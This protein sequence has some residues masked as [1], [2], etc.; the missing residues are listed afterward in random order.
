MFWFLKVNH[1]MLNTVISSVEMNMSFMFPVDCTAALEHSKVQFL[2]DT[3][4]PNTTRY[5]DEY[6][7]HLANI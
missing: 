2:S 4:L 1:L 7:T 3:F 5:F 6:W